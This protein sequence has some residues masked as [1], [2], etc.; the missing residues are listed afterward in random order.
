LPRYDYECQECAHVFELK[1]SFDS[2][3]Q[4]TC[5]ICSGESK[6]KFHAVPIIYKGSGFY[7]TDYKGTGYSPAT[8]DVDEGDTAGKAEANAE[9]A[10]TD[11]Q[12]KAN[13]LMESAQAA[14]K[15]TAI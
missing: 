12:N 2:L 15:G 4:G 13:A 8:K 5:P 10:K 6:R 11:D 9:K 1:Q 3:P 7:S 14:K